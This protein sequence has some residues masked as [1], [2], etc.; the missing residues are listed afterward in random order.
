MGLEPINY[1]KLRSKGAAR[2]VRLFFLSKS[3]IKRILEKKME[4]N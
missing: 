4:S 3:E 1:C 2:A